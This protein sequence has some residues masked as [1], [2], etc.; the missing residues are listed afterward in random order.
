MAQ[1]HRT[2]MNRTNILETINGTIRIGDRWPRKDKNRGPPDLPAN[3][4]V[5]R[6]VE[7]CLDS[8][9]VLQSKRTQYLL[10]ETLAVP[11]QF[12]HDS[13]PYMVQRDVN[14]FQ[15]IQ[16]DLW[17]NPLNQQEVDSLTPE[18]I[19]FIERHADA[20]PEKRYHFWPVDI[21]QQ[22]PDVQP[23][24][25]ALIV[26][27]L[28]HRRVKGDD[29]NAPDD[30]LLGP[31]NY[32][33]SYAVLTPDHGQM[34]RDSEDAIAAMLRALL[35]IMGITVD[36]Q[37]TREFTW[38]P[39]MNA[40]QRTPADLEYWSTGLRVFEMTRIWLER[41]SQLY[42]VNPH[43]HDPV[44]FWAAHSGW[45]NVDAVRSSMIGMAATM[46]N[47]SMNSTTR[48]AIEP[49]LDNSIQHV[50][51]GTTI[52]SQSMMPNR[53]RV[54]AFIPNASRKNPVYILD[55]PGAANDGIV[56]EEEDEEDDDDDE[57]DGGEDDND[58]DEEA[59]EE[60]VRPRKRTGIYGQIVF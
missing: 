56:D 25:W 48:I 30:P 54:G 50:P 46:V 53:R 55:H 3:F 18:V 28:T 4:R 14:I 2:A 52:K 34:A 16:Q 10:G 22:D 9:Q 15:P 23:P 42:C 24:H 32:L 40:P 12:L 1:R 49:I 33:D 45:F 17:T 41:L 36:N 31:Y 57:G 29:P 60:E 8:L 38:I 35:P 43:G 11:L 6:R 58:D 21:S 19:E 27:H 26:L 13:L 51:S 39:P 47:R 20:L 37:S 7:R 59:E 5:S 44:K